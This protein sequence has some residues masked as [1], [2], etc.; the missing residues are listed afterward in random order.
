MPRVEY[1]T[2]TTP[3]LWNQYEWLQ[4]RYHKLKRNH[5]IQII[6]RSP[7]L[8]TLEI[9]VEEHMTQ[10]QLKALFIESR[11][12]DIPPLKA[13][14][15]FAPPGDRT[16]GKILSTIQ[17]IGRLSASVTENSEANALRFYIT[18]EE[19]ENPKL[20]SK[21]P[22]L[23]MAEKDEELRSISEFLKEWPGALEELKEFKKM[24]NILRQKPRQWP[25]TW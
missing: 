4:A 10:D 17:T 2:I 16:I 11:N 7:G 3:R 20:G 15:G 23:S 8:E 1:R 19:E 14:L 21:T 12:L 22:L 5:R 13:R 18:F 24:R 25:R 6:L 9:R